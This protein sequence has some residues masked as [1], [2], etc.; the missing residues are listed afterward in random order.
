MK[1]LKT[2]L[3]IAIVLLMVMS[4]SA[5]DKGLMVKKIVIAESVAEREPVNVD[6]V[7]SADIGKV[8]CHTVIVNGDTSRTIT[9]LWKYEG[10]AVAEVGL[11]I[12]KS[13]KW[14]TWTSKTINKKQ[15]GKW[16]VKVLNENGDVLATKCFT[17]K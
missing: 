5:Q 7:F 17:I 1:I 6:T 8:F 3:P 10:E 9:H 11:E 2:L 16:Q 13:S 14:R 15:T 12:K 4:V